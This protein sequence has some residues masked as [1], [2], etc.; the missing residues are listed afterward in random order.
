M[1]GCCRPRAGGCTRSAWRRTAARLPGSGRALLR[2]WWS[3]G[4]C[5]RATPRRLTRPSLPTVWCARRGSLCSRANTLQW[6][7]FHLVAGTATGV[8]SMQ[9][10]LFAVGLGAGAVPMAAA[11]NWVLKDG[12]GQVRLVSAGTLHKR[13]LISTCKHVHIPVSQPRA[14]HEAW[15]RAIRQCVWHA[16]RPAAQAPP[17]LCDRLDA[18]RNNA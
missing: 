4:S 3:G 14:D 10:L 1:P 11:V 6:Q 18:G 9:A 7:F 8:L 12:L 16:L 2:R 13:T 17:L 5:R 15:W